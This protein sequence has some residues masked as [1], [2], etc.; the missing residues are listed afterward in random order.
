MLP[1]EILTSAL[2]RTAVLMTCYNRRDQTLECLSALQNQEGLDNINL[3]IYLV[4]DGCTDGTGK[5]VRDKYPE[6]TV[7]RGD[8]SLYWGGG[9]NLAW[10]EAMK[11]DYD[12]YLW[13][14]D[15]TLLFKDAMKVLLKTFRQKLKEEGKGGI[16]IGSCCDPKTGQFSY[17]GRIRKERNKI[18]EP[19]DHAQS[20]DLMN[21]NIVLISRGIVKDIGILSHEFQHTAGDSD[22]GLRAIE[23]GYIIWV[24][25]GYQGS[26]APHTYRPWN[27]PEIPLRERWRY[28]C[29]PKGNPPHEIYLFARRHYGFFWPIV[30]M[31]LYLRV[32][33]PGFYDKVKLIISSEGKKTR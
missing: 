23:A 11:E 27:D 29:S 8:G 30:I 28:L 24:A 3:R 33:I 22:Y 9:T 13:L 12:F 31:K 18:V 26:C 17:G 14:N 16:I 25:P 2:C 15:D 6:V 7:L 1:S 10:T 32:L 20:C 5:A 21:G 4:D 19:G